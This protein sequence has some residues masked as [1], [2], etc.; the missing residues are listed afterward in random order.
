MWAIGWA[1]AATIGRSQTAD[2]SNA[3]VAVGTNEVAVVASNVTSDVVTNIVVAP[4]LP[5]LVLKATDGSEIRWA[6]FADRPLLLLFWATWDEP[7]QRQVAEVQKLLQTVS[8]EVAVVGIALDETAASVNRFVRDQR[9]SFPTTLLTLKLLEDYG[10]LTAI[11]T[12]VLL[13]R[14]H[15]PFRRY[16]GLTEAGALARDLRTL[17]IPAPGP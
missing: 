5:R 6:E 2:V 15:L 8:N 4:P 14:F 12:M 16:V 7:S 13:D 3:P 9:L 10:E 1:V 17:P 11:P